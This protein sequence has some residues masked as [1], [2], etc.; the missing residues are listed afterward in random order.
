MFHFRPQWHI[1]KN[2]PLQY[3]LIKELP[4]LADFAFGLFVGFLLLKSYNDFG[5]VVLNSLIGATMCFLSMFIAVNIIPKIGIGN[6]LR[7]SFFI[8]FLSGLVIFPFLHQSPWV[9]LLLTGFK[10][11]AAG[12]YWGSVNILELNEFKTD[13]RVKM[14]SFMIGL[15]RVLFTFL[16]II[17][18]FLLTKYNDIMIVMLPYVFF[19]GIAVLM[20]LD[21][22]DVNYTK[23]SFKKLMHLHKRKYFGAIVLFRFLGSL[24]AAL[25]E[26]MYG[27]LPLVIFSTAFEIGELSTVTGLVSGLFSFILIKMTFAQKEKWSLKILWITALNHLFLIF[28]L[29]PVGYYIFSIV[30]SFFGIL[31][32]PVDN[33]LWYRSMKVF[34]GDDYHISLETTIFNEFVMITGRAIVWLAALAIIRATNNITII[35]QAVIAGYLVIYIIRFLIFSK[36]VDRHVRMLE[37]R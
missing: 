32:D 20:P 26:T 2:K 35:L 1:H 13:G 30:Q 19:W 23:F 31:L 7:V 36:F 3:V 25:G 33:E 34:V 8:S 6:N 10:G 4:A 37:T 24:R 15:D 14:F 29:N 28:M 22:F 21:F 16:P 11:L 9:L 18:G 5:I 17:A 12:F 27:I